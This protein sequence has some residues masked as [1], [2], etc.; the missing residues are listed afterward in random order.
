MKSFIKITCLFA[1]LATVEN[2]YSATA[3]ITN[4]TLFKVKASLDIIAYPDP[5]KEIGSNSSVSEDIGTFFMRG[6]T[7]GVHIGDQFIENVL[8]ESKSQTLGLGDINYYI[9]AD[10]KSLGREKFVDEHVLEV[11]FY[12]IRCPKFIYSGGI[13]CVSNPIKVRTK[14]F[15]TFKLIENNGNQVP[16]NQ[17]SVNYDGTVVR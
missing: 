13:M 4:A 17:P 11:I 12:L 3:N 16:K 15:E 10:V 7:V 6:I 9:F 2:L 8:S 5:Q 1:A 14:D